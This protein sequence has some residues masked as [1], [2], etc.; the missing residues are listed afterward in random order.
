MLFRSALNETDYPRV[1]LTPAIGIQFGKETQLKKVLQLPVAQRDAVLKDL[2]LESES[3]VFVFS[4]CGRRG[5]AMSG[6]GA[7]GG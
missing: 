1:Q 6:K 5:H 2:A 3:F 7:V 4:R